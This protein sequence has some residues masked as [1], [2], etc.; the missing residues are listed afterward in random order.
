MPAFFCDRPMLHG[1]VIRF[2]V[3]SIAIVASQNCIA[4][5]T[6]DPFDVLFDIVT[7]RKAP[8][9]TVVVPEAETP[10]LWKNSRY[11]V[12][13]GAKKKLQDALQALESLPQKEMESHT[14]MQRAVLQHHLWCIFD[15]TTIPADQNPVTPLEFNAV[16]SRVSSDELFRLQKMLASAIRRLA[17]PHQ[18]ILR[19]PSPLNSTVAAQVYSADV[20]K[21]DAM[22]PYL[23]TD[24]I[25]SDGPWVCLHKPD[26]AVPAT[27]HAEAVDFRSAFL[28]LLR[29]PGGRQK[30]I[31]YL[32]EL[33]AFQQPFVP[34]KQEPFVS[35]A[36]H[37]DLF[38]LDLHANPRTPNFPAGT[39]VALVKQALLIDESGKPVLSPLIQ[40]IQ[41][42]TYLNV[43]IDARLNNPALGPSQAVAEFVLQPGQMMQGNTPMRAVVS[44]EMRHT[45]TFVHSDPIENPR[46]NNRAPAPRLRSCVACH[47]SSGVHSINARHELFQRKSV[48]PPRLAAST[49]AAV[50]T[51]TI[52]AKRRTYS[53]GLLQGLQ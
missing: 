24:I 3:W 7:I 50:G 37:Q 18:E 39:Q 32:A 52:I 40:S 25:D 6:A 42:R 17:L 2:L 30:T 29:L 16:E 49:P 11:L 8:D 20:D 1:A 21:S 36:G 14:P 48:L 23:P 43:S 33:N 15:W 44:G 9:G 27:L 53:W 19:L 31:E 38:R 34:G 10:R 28:I 12:E 4:N 13:D 41:L 51:A 35:I 46:T 45:N 47:S 22:K 5:E 26:Y